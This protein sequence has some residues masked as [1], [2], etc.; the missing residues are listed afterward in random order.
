MFLW[1]LKTMWYV[2]FENIHLYDYTILY[3]LCTTRVKERENSTPLI[4]I[5]GINLAL[6]DTK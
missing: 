4:S 5:S 3:S 2:I 6:P 1:Y